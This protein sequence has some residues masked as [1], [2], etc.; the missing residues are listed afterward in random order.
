[1]KAIL[2]MGWQLI[3]FRAGPEALP[4]A[5]RLILPLVILNLLLGVALQQLAG[6][7]FDK[8]V[9]QLSAMA[10]AAEAGWLWLLLQRRGWHNRWV[11]AYA[12]MVLIDTLI[13]LIASP[14][15]LLQAQGGAFTGVAVV[16]QIVMTLWSLSARAFVY[17]QAL[18]VSRFKGFFLALAPLFAVMALAAMLFPDLLPPPP[19][20][21]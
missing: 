7:G 11:Q 15:V 17:Q 19:Q 16:L 4:Y 3:C 9:L 18:D 14:L 20:G 5:P 10:L 6:S 1:M 12:G 13:T 21:N 8:P 2:S